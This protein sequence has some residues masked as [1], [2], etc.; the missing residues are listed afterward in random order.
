MTDKKPP[1]P[2]PKQPPPKD[3]AEPKR[4]APDNLK[5]VHGGR[6]WDPRPRT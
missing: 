1:P 4:P 5:T 2:P 6:D 3:S